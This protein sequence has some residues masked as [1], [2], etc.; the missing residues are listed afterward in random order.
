MSKFSKLMKNPRLFF[1]DAFKKRSAAYRAVPSNNPAASEAST[2]T[3]TYVFGF[4][5]WKSF[6]R[7]WFPER[8]LIFLPKTLSKADFD[9]NWA[10]KIKEKIGRAH[11]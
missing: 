5:P 4:S 1:H 7:D 11:V 6:L 3:P 10:K 2:L 8:K 9:K